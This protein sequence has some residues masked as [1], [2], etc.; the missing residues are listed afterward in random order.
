[1][2]AA[3]TTPFTP[4]HSVVRHADGRLT[5]RGELSFFTIELNRLGAFKSENCFD[6][7]AEDYCAGWLTGHRC[8]AELLAALECTNGPRI[9]VT[10]VIEDAIHAGND[11]TGKPGRRG[12][13]AAFM[14]VMAEAVKFMGKHGN[15][16]PWLERKIEMAEKQRDF[17]AE[18]EAR[19]RA[20]FNTRMKSARQAKRT[21]QAEKV[22]A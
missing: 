7:P 21:K 15:N 9:D 4:V 10:R 6:V 3:T 16:R 14:E 11:P 8:A 1:M 5:Q 18:R 2:N 20:E 19:H 12:A 22:A 17:Y 13:S